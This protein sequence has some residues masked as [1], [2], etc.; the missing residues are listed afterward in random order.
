MGRLGVLIYK[1]GEKYLLRR[2]NERS[3]CF[4][5]STGKRRSLSLSTRDFSGTKDEKEGGRKE[6]FEILET[7]LLRL[8]LV[9]FQLG[10]FRKRAITL[11]KMARFLKHPRTFT[12]GHSRKSFTSFEICMCACVPACARLFK[13]RPIT[14]DYFLLQLCH[15]SEDS[16]TYIFILK[17]TFHLEVISFHLLSSA[18][19]WFVNREDRWIFLRFFFVNPFRE[20]ILITSN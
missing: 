4:W 17:W 6:N 1:E 8:C 19:I 11:F 2:V 15:E 14:R 13:D 5:I 7:T 9:F 18:R 16:S 10:E 20:R 3:F 12:S